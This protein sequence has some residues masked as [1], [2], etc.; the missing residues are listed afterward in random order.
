MRAPNEK[1]KEKN[2][3]GIVR[4]VWPKDYKDI[5]GYDIKIGAYV[6][7]QP[8]SAH[9]GMHIGQVIKIGHNDCIKIKTAENKTIVRHGYELV[10]VMQQR[11]AFENTLEE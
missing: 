6:I 3:D 9:G 4:T 2:E 5:F 7:W 8:Y 1:C 11:M 10:L